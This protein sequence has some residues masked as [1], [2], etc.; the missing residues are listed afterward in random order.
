MIFSINCSWSLHNSSTLSPYCVY[1]SPYVFATVPK[2][3]SLITGQFSCLFS[4]V[5]PFW[6]DAAVSKVD[7][8]ALRCPV[9]LFCRWILFGA[10]TA[11]L[12]L[13]GDLL[14]G[15]DTVFLMPWDPPENIL[16]LLAPVAPVGL[17][18]G[19]RVDGFTA[20]FAPLGDLF[21]S[22]FWFVMAV[23]FRLVTFALLLYLG[24]C[25]ALGEGTWG[26]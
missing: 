11:V 7:Y 22:K 23:E 18:M 14:S 4:E 3:G 26:A 10:W 8:C 17:T 15:Y 12:G 25:W 6:D 20:T 5:S 19:I 24:D 16:L 21:R 2:S 1:S 9:G 13:W